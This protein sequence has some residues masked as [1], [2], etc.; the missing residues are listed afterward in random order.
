MAISICTVPQ[1]ESGVIELVDF[2]ARVIKHLDVRKHVI[3]VSD[4]NKVG[5]EWED[6][7]WFMFKSP[8]ANKAEKELG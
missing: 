5:N 1:N 2:T 8:S 6:N 3:V 7:D 4:I